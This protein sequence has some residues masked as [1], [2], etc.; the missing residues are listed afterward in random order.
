[1]S[2]IR[3]VF[4]GEDSVEVQVVAAQAR[5]HRPCPVINW[6]YL[7]LPSMQIKKELRLLLSK[8]SCD[9]GFFTP[10]PQAQSNLNKVAAKSDGRFPCDLRWALNECVKLNYTAVTTVVRP[11]VVLNVNLMSP[12]N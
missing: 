8:L 10:L 5:W 1:M 9:G 3:Y 12:S 4:P 6:S 2:P 7:D 11:D